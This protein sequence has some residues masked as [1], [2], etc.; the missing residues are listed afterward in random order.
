ML[1][2]CANTNEINSDFEGASSQLFE[3]D[4]YRISTKLN[5][6]KPNTVKVSAVTFY[7]RGKTGVELRWHTKQEFCDISS[8][9]NDELTSWQGCNEGKA[10][11]KKQRTIN[12]KK[13]KSDP[14]NADKGNW[15]NKFKKAT[16]AQ[17]GISHGMSI[18]LKEEINNSSPI[19][20]LQPPLT[21]VPSKTPLILHLPF[22]NLAPTIAAAAAGTLAAAFPD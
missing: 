3:V 10:S 15:K 7:G 9:Q 16:K 21:P 19:A 20:A 14:D 1:N 5:P 6:I 8:D 11:T 2:F 4:P 13:Q 22:I 17:S 12:S 18:M